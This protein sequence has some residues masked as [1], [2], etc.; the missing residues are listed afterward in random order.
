MFAIESRDATT[1]GE[2]LDA[3]GRRRRPVARP[4]S[5]R[6]RRP[7]VSSA[8]VVVFVTHGLPELR[9]AL[10]GIRET[11]PEGTEFAVVATGRGDQ[12]ATYLLRQ[13]LRG[14]IDVLDFA[15]R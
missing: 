5:L 12:D 1:F 6:R 15:R 10:R 11:I 7:A 8:G 4:W 14:R 2:D 9:I 3:A 13:H